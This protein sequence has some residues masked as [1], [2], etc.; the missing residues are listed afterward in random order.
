MLL[1]VC[2]NSSAPSLNKQFFSIVD[3]VLLRLLLNR[4]FMLCRLCLGVCR[5][6]RLTTTSRQ[7]GVCLGAGC[8]QVGLTRNMYNDNVFFDRRFNTTDYY[9]DRSTKDMAEYRGYAVIME[10]SASQFKTSK[11]I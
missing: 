6:A 11:H 2:F 10:S 7:D 8:C 1:A 4:M 9:T 3:W 5:S